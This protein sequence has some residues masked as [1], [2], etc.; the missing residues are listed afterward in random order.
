MTLC[1]LI[2]GLLAASLAVAGI[3]L[4]A[5]GALVA[6]SVLLAL[7]L[8]ANEVL[9]DRTLPWLE[10]HRTATYTTAAALCIATVFSRNPRLDP[11]TVALFLLASAA[12]ALAVYDVATKHV[13]TRKAAQR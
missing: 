5:G 12:C 10:R 9:P 11:T 4:P 7:D 3:L 13:L 2:R 6:S 8:V 1:V